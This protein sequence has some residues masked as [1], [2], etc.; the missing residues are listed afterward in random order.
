MKQLYFEDIKSLACDITDTFDA[1]E[2]EFRDVS[3]I[4][5][6]NE[7]NEIV[8]ELLC[9]G[10]DIASVE[11]HREEFEEYWDEYILSL[12]SD[13]IWCEK[14]KNEA[15]Y[16]TAESNVIYIMDNCSS[17]VIPYC[18]SEDVYEV[19]VG[20]SDAEESNE[21]SYMVNGKTV[22]KEEF[23]NYVSKFAPVSDSEDEE[24]NMPGNDNYS[25]TVKCNLDA[26]EALEIIK[27]IE[28]RIMNV[29]DMLREMDCFRRLF[30]W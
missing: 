30:N 26:H 20:D 11:L 5:K 10:Y 15:E 7:V 9:L 19:S 28:R 3:V 24:D 21:H 16:L 1:L 29:D 27:D 18:Q 25:I 12:S 8:R 2:D 22:D 4:A 17:N 13:G 23:D 6:Y 14:F